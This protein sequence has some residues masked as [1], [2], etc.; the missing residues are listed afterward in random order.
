MTVRV[1]DRGLSQVNTRD[2]KTIRR[3]FKNE[4]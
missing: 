3:W 1:Y 4:L 2:A